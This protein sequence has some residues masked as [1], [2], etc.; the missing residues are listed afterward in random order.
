MSK[1]SILWVGLG[2]LGLPVAVD[3]AKKYKVYGYDMNPVGFR[4]AINGHYVHKE[5]GPTG[6]DDFQQHFNSVT[7]YVKDLRET[8][9]LLTGFLEQG[10]K[11]SDI[12]FLAVQTPHPPEFD[13]T[14]ELPWHER[15]DFDYSYLIQSCKELAPYVKP[16]QTL[17]IVSTVL[18]GT[19]RREI[20]PILGGRCN[21]VYNPFF[22]ALGTVMKDFLNP[23]FVLIGEEN[24]NAQ[25]LVDLYWDFYGKNETAFPAA[26]P[27]TFLRMSIESA[28]LAKVA[29]NSF[30][31]QKISFLNSLAMMAHEIPHAN[32]DE[33]GRIFESSPRLIKSFSKAGMGF[34]GACFPRDCVAMSHLWRDVLGLYGGDFNHFEQALW[35][36]Q[37]YNDWLS[38]LVMEEWKRTNLPIVVLGKAFKPETN[39]TAGS[40]ALLLFEAIVAKTNRSVFH[41]DPFIDPTKIVEQSC[42]V[43]AI[44][45][46]STKHEQFKDYKFAPGSVVIDPFR[47]IKPQDGV[48]VIPIG[49]GK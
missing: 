8:S 27:P 49:V 47:Y 33:V 23:E 7:T 36:K 38:D 12:I 32:V 34:G 10:V 5:M 2:K 45:V 15:A 37:N 30:I 18:P 11:S 28:E 24:G 17:V 6:Q 9:L 21:V 26:K 48:T 43:P 13:G 3:L 20:L 16:H 19:I 41:Y 1:P 35:H 22:I 25:A 29:Y 46:I 14:S 40:P 42:Y 39:L 4:S 31:S 44:Y